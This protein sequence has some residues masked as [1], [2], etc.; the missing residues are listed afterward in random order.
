MPITARRCYIH[1]T[2]TRT[3]ESLYSFCMLFQ[4]ETG[5]YHGRNTTVRLTSLHGWV[6]YEVRVRLRSGARPP[7]S[8]DNG[9]DGW[10]SSEAS[11]NAFT[12]QGGNALGEGAK[13]VMINV[14]IMLVHI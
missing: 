10:W 8:P 14:C 13:V 7:P 4:N 12:P 2:H 1:I 3:H 11:G 6:D 5:F 9:T